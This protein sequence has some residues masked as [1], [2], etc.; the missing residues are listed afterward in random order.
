MVESAV[1]YPYY[2][3]IGIKVCD[4]WLGRDGFSNF[5]KDM[6]ERP[7]GHTIERRE[8]DK[9]YNPENCYWLPA[10]LQARNT[11]RTVYVTVNG[12]R[13]KLIDLRDKYGIN[14]STIYY[15]YRRGVRGDK[16]IAPAHKNVRWHG[17]N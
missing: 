16:L 15:R 10:K 1:P 4:R 6:G 17:P 3:G 13:V 11:H 8:V 9:G 14:A 12:E 7:K 5:I 2:G